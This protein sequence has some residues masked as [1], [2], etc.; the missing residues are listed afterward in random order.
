LDPDGKLKH[1]MMSIANGS[2][3]VTRV[4]PFGLDNDDVFPEE[5]GRRSKAPK[6]R[7][8]ATV[9]SSMDMLKC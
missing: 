8:E 5:E 2:A 3:R 1:R 6:L 9:D 7:D 4:L